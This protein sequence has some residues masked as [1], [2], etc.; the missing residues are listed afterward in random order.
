[1][2]RLTCAFCQR[3]PAGRRRDQ[4]PDAARRRGSTA[5]S[6]ARR[7]RGQRPRLLRAQRPLLRHRGQDLPLGAI[8]MSL[9][10]WAPWREDDANRRDLQKPRRPL[11]LAKSK[12]RSAVCCAPT[13][14]SNPAPL[15]RLRHRQG[16]P[17][18]QDHLPLQ[19]YHAAN[20]IVERVVKGRIKKGLIWHFQGSGQV[21]ADRLRGAEAAPAP[22]PAQPHRVGR[23]GSGGPA[24]ADHR[25]F[26]TWPTCPTW[27]PWTA[28]IS[29]NAALPGC[30]EDH[31]HHYPQ[32]R[33]AGAQDQP[34]LEHHRHGGRGAPHPG[35]GLRPA[36]PATTA[37]AAA[38]RAS[39]GA[40]AAVAA[41][42]YQQNEARY[43]ALQFA[44]G[45]RKRGTMDASVLLISGCQ[46]NHF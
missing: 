12:L 28:V 26:S 7:L 10:L 30:A 5:R 14:S 37:R 33:R 18:D 2:R 17:Q 45:S 29:W 9:D 16:A 13:L 20:Q 23:G 43:N 27:S 19:Q 38:C 36:A 35:R 25:Q 44:S 34:P 3:L 11:D 32:V 24:D 40:P 31:H 21:A 46:D 15:H 6:S 39:V 41:A 22:Q 42:N 1:M 4:V 8:R